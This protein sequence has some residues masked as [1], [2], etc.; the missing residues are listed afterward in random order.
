MK[1]HQKYILD[2]KQKCSLHFPGNQKLKEPT[3]LSM[4]IMNC[5]HRKLKFKNDSFTIFTHKL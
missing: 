3:I 4:N 2:Y 5:F 1:M